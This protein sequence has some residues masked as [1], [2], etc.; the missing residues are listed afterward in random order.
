MNDPACDYA[1]IE[2]VLQGNKEA[3]TLLV[4]KYKNNLYRLLRGMGASPQDAQDLTQEAFIKSYQK[5]R[6][7]R[8][9]SSFAAWLYAIAINLFRDQARRKNLHTV[10]AV[11]SDIPGTLGIPE[12]SYMH[13][14]SELALSRRLD[15]LPETY[16]IVLLLRY[17]NELSYEEISLITGM[18]LNRIKNAL[19]RAKK[20][21]RKQLAHEEGTIHEMLYYSP[22]GRSAR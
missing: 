12:D 21:L 16:R 3:F 8:R 7:F 18:P 6:D 11:T 9:D 2:E 14:E 19:H 4:G 13:K 17:S 15:N 1:H 10:Q 22:T 5:L 20:K